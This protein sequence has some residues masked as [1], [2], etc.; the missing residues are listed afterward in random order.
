M[1]GGGRQRRWARAL[2]GLGVDPAYALIL[3]LGTLIW[4]LSRSHPALL[5]P[6]M[7]W[8]FSPVVY[9]AT[10]LSLFWF[11]RGLSLTPASERSA[12]WRRV[13]F[14]LGVAAIYG[15]L[16]TR[17]EY[18]SQHMFFLN[19]AQ[20]VVMHHLGPF[21]VALGAAGGTIGRGMPRRCHQIARSGPVAAVLRVVQQ[22]LM[23]AVLFVGSFYFWLIPTVHFRAMIDARLYA[24]MNWS[25]VLDGILFWWLVLDPRPSP[26]ARASYGARAALALGVMFP[27]IALGAAVT[28]SRSDLYPYYDLC[29]RLFPSISALNDQHIG[30]IVIWIPPAMMSVI[31][32]LLVIN[33]LRLHEEANVETSDDAVALANLASSWTGR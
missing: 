33:A 22:P 1:I 23:A 31:A 7:P 30:G 13:A 29:G 8:D 19:R 17:F 5:P 14:V 18:W 26:P 10:A 6:W 16:Q 12:L 11:F 28:F 15:V 25:M 24:L 32:V 4:W 2:D 3:V 27:Q 21:L 9:L 20:H